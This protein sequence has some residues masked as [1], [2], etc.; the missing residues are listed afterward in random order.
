MLLID[1]ER[2]EV[3]KQQEDGQVSGT[4]QLLGTKA[5]QLEQGNKVVLDRNP[6]NKAGAHESMLM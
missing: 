6:E 5:G 2:K 4:Q 1:P 3:V